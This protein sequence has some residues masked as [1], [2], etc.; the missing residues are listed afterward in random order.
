MGRSVI[1]CLLAAGAGRAA[2]AGGGFKVDS[3]AVRGGGWAIR[4][5][6]DLPGNKGKLVIK[7]QKVERNGTELAATTNEIA[8]WNS[9]EY[10]LSA[11]GLADGTR[12]VEIHLYQIP[13]A[14]KDDSKRSPA[15]ESKLY[16][17]L[18]VSLGDPV[19][20]EKRQ[21]ITAITVLPMAYSRDNAI[22]K[23]IKLVPEKLDDILDKDALKAGNISIKANMTSLIPANQGSRASSPTP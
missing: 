22:Q 5:G 10:L 19:G 16:F 9:S 4:L 21:I 15:P 11:L 7:G 23:P 13:Y 18:K 6:A 12:E 1:I 14:S 8:L 20:G 2:L 17:A 3:E